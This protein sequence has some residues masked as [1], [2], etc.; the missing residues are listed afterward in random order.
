MVGVTSPN[1]DQRHQR[2]LDCHCS[3]GGD[4]IASV[5]VFAGEADFTRH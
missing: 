5:A 2:R 3:D 1:A 4:I